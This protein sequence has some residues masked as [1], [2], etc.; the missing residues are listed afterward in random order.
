M[1]MER[2]PIRPESVIEDLYNGQIIQLMDELHKTI[3]LMEYEHDD[4]WSFIIIKI[5]NRDYNSTV[6]NEV[7]RRYLQEGWG[8]VFY[9]SKEGQLSFQLYFPQIKEGARL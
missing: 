5:K 2:K 1:E 6:L 3:S 7:K 8:N 9:N 4:K